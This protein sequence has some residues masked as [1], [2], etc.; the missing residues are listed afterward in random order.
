MPPMTTTANTTMTS[1]LPLRLTRITGADSTPPARPVLCH[2]IGHCTSS[3]T[4]TPKAAAAAG[5][6]CGAQRAPRRV[7]SMMNQNRKTDDHRDEDHPGAI[8]RQIMNRD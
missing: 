6:R 2:H 7:R 4:L 8:D 5:S 1:E 3:G